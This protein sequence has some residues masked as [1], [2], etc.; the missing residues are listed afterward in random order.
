MKLDFI[1]SENFRGTYIYRQ[2]D[3]LAY[4]YTTTHFSVDADGAPNAYHPDDVGK[5]CYKDVHVGLECLVQ[6]GYPNTSW[7]NKVLV[8]DP[9]ASSRAY[10]QPDGPFAGY[11]VCMTSLRASGGNKYDPS[12]YVDATKVPYVVIPT[13]FE[14]LP[15]VGKQGDVGFAT[16]LES[17]RTTA[18]IIADAG[19][20]ADAKLGESSIALFEKLGGKDVDPRTGSGVLPGTYQYIIFRNSALPGKA[21]W[22]R[23]NEA[24]SQQV[25]GLLK[26][27]PG[28]ST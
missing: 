26:S 16:H 14:K 21:K 22:P 17:G 27:V 23:S 13:G 11:F 5:N 20:G 19:G 15:Q 8:P 4:A 10:V 12:T 28:I 18:F 9:Q 6:A 7:W 24:I 1:R 3:N 25:A 2:R